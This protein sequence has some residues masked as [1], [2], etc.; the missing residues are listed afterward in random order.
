MACSYEKWEIFQLLYG[1]LFRTAKPIADTRIFFGEVG[2]F[3]TGNSFVFFGAEYNARSHPKR[4][5]PVDDKLPV[6]LV[7]RPGLLY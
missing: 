2:Q 6:P 3:I 7:V 5:M 4:L 1:R